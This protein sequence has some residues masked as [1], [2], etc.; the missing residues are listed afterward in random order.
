[1]TCYYVAIIVLSLI[2]CVVCTIEI[3]NSVRSRGN[4]DA[5]AGVFQGFSTTSGVSLDFPEVSEGNE[6]RANNGVANAGA[7]TFFG[8]NADISGAEISSETS[9]QNN[10]AQSG[11]NTAVSGLQTVFSDVADSQLNLTVN[12]IGND[13]S[14]TRSRTSTPNIAAISGSQMQ[15]GSAQNVSSLIEV[16]ARDND[17]NSRNDAQAISGSDTAFGTV[18][19]SQLAIDTAVDDNF[20]SSVGGA[21]SSGAK[22]SF[23]SVSNSSISSDS[24]SYDNEAQS[25]GEFNNAVAGVQDNFGIVSATSLGDTLVTLDQTAYNN[26]AGAND[27]GIAVG[28]VQTSAGALYNTVFVVDGNAAHNEGVVDGVASIDRDA[29]AGAS[30]SMGTVNASIVLFNF[31]TSEND[32]YNY[33]KVDGTYVGGD[34]TAGTQVNIENLSNSVL[35]TNTTSSFNKGYS[36]Y[37]DAVA[38]N[39]VNIVNMTSSLFGFTMNAYNN[40]AYSLNADAVAG[41]QVNIDNAVGNAGLLNMTAVNNTAVTVNGDAVAGNQINIDYASNNAIAYNV[42]GQNNTAVSIFGAAVTTSQININ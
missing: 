4:N 6:A 23:S 37:G 28:G 8:A 22:N 40:T 31:N 30:V 25:S 24:L 27:G 18:S 35:I 20:A 11:S 12:G 16:D 42:T 41:N 5:N 13:A 3:G 19:D 7:R 17:A 9:V 21:A 15:F 2:G 36:A 1:M 29:I 10:D 34:A 14:I 38:G 39:Q 33:Q 32:A 26:S